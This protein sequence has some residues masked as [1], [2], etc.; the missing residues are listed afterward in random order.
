[1][2]RCDHAVFRVADLERSVEF[3][4]RLLPAELV[5]RRQGKDRWRS[6]VA[7]LRPAGQ[8]GF[9]VILIMARRVRWLLW[10]FHRLVPRQ[11][12]SHEHLGFACDSLA[13]LEQREQLARELGARIQEPVTRVEEKEGWLLEVI[14][15]DGNAIEWTYGFSHG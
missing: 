10:L 4:T 15:P 9:V 3:Y 2:P 11:A 12:R 5:S 7:T 6:E 14:D 1:M 8:Q 13:D